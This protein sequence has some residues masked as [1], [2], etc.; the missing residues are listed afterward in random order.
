MVE[1]DHVFVCIGATHGLNGGGGG[2]GG[3]GAEFCNGRSRASSSVRPAG[4][5][6]VVYRDSNGV[7]WF[8]GRTT[9]SSGSIATK[10]RSSQLK[11]KKIL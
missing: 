5:M 7:H 3:C 2:G 8:A 11:F 9:G 4:I 10:N 1:T 6:S